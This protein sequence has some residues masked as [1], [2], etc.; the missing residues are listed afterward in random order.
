[1]L[2]DEKKRAE[3]EYA[4]V[5]TKTKGY[6]GKFFIDDVSEKIVAIDEKTIARVGYS[7]RFSDEYEIEIWRRSSTGAVAKIKGVD[8]N[9]DASKL[10]EKAVYIL[11]KDIRRS[12]ENIPLPGEIHGCEVFDVKSGE[13]IGA[14]VE[15]WELPGNDVWIIETEN[16]KTPAPV[17]DDVVKKIDVEN[18]RV[19][20]ELIEGLTDL[21]FDGS[22][23]ED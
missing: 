5:I 8:S 3:Y 10:K 9:I 16:G 11:K 6:R 12:A 20:I 21:N 15:I 23:D 13:K 18:K 4:G 22:D 2:Q 7:L 17:I 19:E 14:I 1:M